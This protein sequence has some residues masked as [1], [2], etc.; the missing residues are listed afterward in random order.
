MIFPGF[1]TFEPTAPLMHA[2]FKLREA[3]PTDCEC[4]TVEFDERGAT[5]ARAYRPNGGVVD[6][7][8]SED[9]MGYAGTLLSYISHQ[10]IVLSRM[11]EPEGDDAV[12]AAQNRLAQSLAEVGLSVGILAAE[13]N[14]SVT[15]HLR[16]A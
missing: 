11:Y 15:I 7:V 8:L 16:H 5:F 10:V 4:I 13:I 2:I 9:E 14:D 12:F 3:G 1:D 6:V